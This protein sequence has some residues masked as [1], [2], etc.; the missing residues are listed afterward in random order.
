MSLYMVT[1]SEQL[2]HICITPEIE[3]KMIEMELD[4]G[5]AVSLIS[6]EKYESN[7]QH[8]S[9]QPTDIILK[10][11]MGEALAP[12]GVISVA[13]KLN[14]HSTRLPLYIVNSD[15]PPLFGREWLRAIKL[16]WQDVKTVR[17]GVTDTIDTVLKRHSQVFGKELGTMKGIEA[18]ITL[19]PDHTP[20]FFQPR[21]IP[22][23]IRPKVET[24]LTRLTELGVISPIQYSEWATP[25]VP[26]IKKDGSVTL[27][28]DFKVTLNP[29]ICVD[30]YPIPA[31][32]I[33][34]HLWLVVNYS[35]SW[36]CQVLTCRC[37]WHWSQEN[38][39]QYPLKKGYF[40]ITV[41]PS[42]SP[43]PLHYFRKQWI[44]FSWGFQTL[45]AI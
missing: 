28:G 21:V 20:K 33:S 4:T 8:I 23:A 26:V 6:K 31:S 25:V 5:A 10:T 16:N 17:H 19:K 9:L 42:G 18:K 41:C 13:V 39:S 22:Y 12:V 36:T 2:A 11:Y 1:R 29:A 35:V 3:G 40:A 24:E 27:C 14:N 43:R 30:H 44:K 34:L 45:T 32:K 37:Q 15:G 7:L 38:Y